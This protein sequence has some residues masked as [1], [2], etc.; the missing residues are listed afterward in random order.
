MRQAADC[1]H[2]LVLVVG[3]A[4]AGKTCVLEAVSKRITAPLVNVN[5]A[6]IRAEQMTS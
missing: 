2:R 5:L 4:G 3:P 6:R 1:H